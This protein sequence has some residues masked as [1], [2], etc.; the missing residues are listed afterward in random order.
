MRRETFAT[1]NTGYTDK[2]GVVYFRFPPDPM[3]IAH[4]SLAYPVRFVPV[5]VNTDHFPTLSDPLHLVMLLV[6]SLVDRH[7]ES[8]QRSKVSLIEF[9]FEKF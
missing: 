9:Y 8:S 6:S 7:L 1:A 3:A 2:T 5:N 4:V